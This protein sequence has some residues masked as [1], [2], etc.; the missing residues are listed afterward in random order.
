[1]PDNGSDL[2]TDES[3]IFLA[4]SR[5]MALL[6]TEVATSKR[7]NIDYAEEWA[8]KPF[9]YLMAGSPYVSRK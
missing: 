7:I 5:S 4:A 3:S 1:M 8:D 2:T 9:R 6:F